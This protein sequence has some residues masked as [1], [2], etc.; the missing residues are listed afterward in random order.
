VTDNDKGRPLDDDH[1]LARVFHAAGLYQPTE[2]APQVDL[3]D[4]P[5]A[6]AGDPRARRYAEAALV[7][8]CRIVATT[9]EGSRNATLHKAAIKVGTLVAAGHLDG[10]DA[11]NQLADAAKQAGLGDR[12]IHRTTRNGF[13]YGM[14]HPREVKLDPPNTTRDA[15]TLDPEEEGIPTRAKD[16]H[17]GQLRIAERFVAGYAWRLLFVH[18]LG[19]HYWTGTHWTEDKNGKSRR[20]VVGLLKKLRHESVNM[21]DKQR[22]R[23]L[24]DV[25]RCESAGGITG[26]LDIARHMRPMS[27]SVEEIDAQP[28]LFNARNGTLNLD[29]GQLQP[30][31]PEDMLTKC[32][33]ADI[34]LDARSVVW[35]NFLATV[36][37]DDDVR[38]YLQ[39]VMGVAMLGKV[40]E[41]ILPILTGTGGNGKSVF[42]D[43]AMEAFGSYG[44]TV[45]PQ[46]IMQTRHARHGTFMADLQGARLV[47]TSETNEG[48]KLAAATVK[49]LTGGDRIRANRM[50]E[51]PFEFA[52]SHTLAFV[53]NHKPSVSADDSAIWR[54]LTVVP[55]DIV[56]PREQQD[57]QLPE[58]IR[59][60]L[61]AVLSWC[62]Q[63]WLD[64][65]AHGLK[66]PAAVQA[67]TDEYRGESDP[68]GQF[69]GEECAT[70]S[71]M[72]KVK[73]KELFDAWAMWAMRSGHQPITQH[74]FGRRIA[75][76]GF[77]RKRGT[78]GPYQ[79]VGI[80][81][82]ANDDDNFKKRPDLWE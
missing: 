40:R 6:S 77:D 80:G 13:D 51:N 66:P 30:H 61:T 2:Q 59:A 73:A 76:R 72:L 60:H 4:M 31:T 42:V 36:L 43:A 46:L 10:N 75:A 48:E 34:D 33:G 70:D 78:G 52:P 71:P 54:R 45:D 7:D 16:I 26:V 22:D 15:F 12:E 27:A 18:G 82:A 29:D 24:S 65:Q 81:L 58:K 56:I 25:K 49:R 23:L 64:Y 53:T 3:S 63:G 21:A 35:E 37:P 62:F 8:E 55:F 20:R 9:G 19:W 28:H 69:I 1:F 5:I 57:Q 41:H 44:L 67:R 68:I 17:S 47:V 79:Y 11:V 50:R 39:R 14:Q 74:E 38:Y 32:A